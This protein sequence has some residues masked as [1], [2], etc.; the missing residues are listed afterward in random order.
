VWGGVH[1][2]VATRVWREL[3]ELQRGGGASGWQ[4]QPSYDDRENG[5]V[6]LRARLAKRERPV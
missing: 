2:Q 1:G 5:T 4:L 6:Y 3:E